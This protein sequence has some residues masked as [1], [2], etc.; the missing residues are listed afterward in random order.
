MR[1][2]NRLRRTIGMLRFKFVPTE[3]L[4][5]QAGSHGRDGAPHT[6]INALK[7]RSAHQ[8][9]GLDGVDWQCAKLNGALLSSCQLAEANLGGAE[10]IGAY[11]GYSNL[12]KASFAK[13]DLRESNLREADLAGAVFDGANLSGANLARADLQGSSFVA[14][15]LTGANLWGADLSGADL[16]CAILTDCCLAAIV[17]DETTAFPEGAIF[18]QQGIAEYNKSYTD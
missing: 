2:T 1:L 7:E 4:I 6:L 14:A 10:L 18:D 15:D 3:E 9:G 12:R 5:A 13:A 16:S 17:V 11:F 8:N